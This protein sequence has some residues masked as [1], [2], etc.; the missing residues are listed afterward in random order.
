MTCYNST[1]IYIYM[2]T[3][4]LYIY[5]YTFIYKMFSYT[6][7]T[8]RTQRNIWI[9]HCTNLCWNLV[10]IASIWGRHVRP[11]ISR[12]LALPY[13]T[14]F[15]PYCWLHPCVLSTIYSYLYNV[16]LDTASETEH[17]KKKFSLTP[18]LDIKH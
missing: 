11:T 1:Y 6:G 15:I 3:H 4:T 13:C 7:T 10:T 12:K 9:G 8:Q 14:I 5:V 17:D 2:Y 18:V 16:S